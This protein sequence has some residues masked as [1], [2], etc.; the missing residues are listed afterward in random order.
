M[1]VNGGAEMLQKIKLK[2]AEK[3]F[4]QLVQKSIQGNEIAIMVDNKPVV[5]L[6]PFKNKTYTRRLGTAKGQV[7]IKDDFKEIPEEFED[8]I[9]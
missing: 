2:D 9:P 3:Y 7:V 4:R 1:L 6:V 5:M 8:Y